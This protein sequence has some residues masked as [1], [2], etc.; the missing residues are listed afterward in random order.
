MGNDSGGDSNGDEVSAGGLDVNVEPTMSLSIESKDDLQITVTKTGIDVFTKLGA[1]N[2]LFIFG[3][4][5]L[6]K[7]FVRSGGP[8]LLVRCPTHLWLPS[9]ARK[10]TNH[11]KY[12]LTFQM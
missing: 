9:H 1:V 12:A 5:R 3:I 7:S 10:S 2:T 4:N 11:G 6:F 8:V